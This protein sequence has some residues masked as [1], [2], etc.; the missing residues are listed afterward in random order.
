MNLIIICSDYPVANKNAES[1]LLKFQL[2]SIKN[3]F[4]RIILLPT[5]SMK[6]KKIIAGLDYK[7]ILNFRS[8]KI[9]YIIYILKYI[10][11]FFKDL[12]KIKFN[13]I[14]FKAAIKSF[15]AYYKSI[16][17]H[18]FFV[19]YFK[20]KENKIENTS[21][22]SFWFSNVTFGALLLKI[23]YP[24]IKIISGAHG[25]D[26]FAER[27]VG[28]RIPFREKSIDL[29]DN[30]IVCSKEGIKYLKEK[31]PL[32]KQKFKLVNSGISNK[33]FKVKSSL[34]GVF[35]VLTLSRTHPVKRISFLLK[36]LK[37]I[38]VFSDF[39]VEYT[40]IGGGPELKDLIKLVKELNFHK[41][42]IK[43]LGKISDLDLENYFKNTPIDVFLNV[44]SSE[45]TC[46]SLVEALSYSIPVL[47]TRVGGN[48]SIG[49][50][51]CTNLNPIIDPKELY[52]YFHQIQID[53]EYREKLKSNSFNY[54]KKNHSSESLSPKIEK[55]F[56]GI[57]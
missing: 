13:K 23:K 45:G 52:S 32:Y 3:S 28:N 29:I 35:R 55:I 21:I 53:E 43:F 37:E 42:K 5:V 38:E 19:E 39:K 54:W 25:Y 46:L 11:F 15:T 50:F 41:F 12:K 51:C 8:F 47:V 36:A 7:I 9:M 14:Y 33:K 30:V 18:T 40:H 6:N 17:L 44:S 16:F 56:R 10:H 27:H 20:N 2:N 57:L 48:I 24:K 34:D 49:K 22:Y 26:L 31:Y 1:S 4:D